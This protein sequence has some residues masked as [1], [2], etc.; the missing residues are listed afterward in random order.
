V[1][2]T[3]EPQSTSI[4]QAIRELQGDTDKPVILKIDIDH[5]EWANFEATPAHD[6]ARCSQIIGEFHGFENALDI[7]WLNRAVA[8]MRK[9][10][11]HFE[12]VHVHANNYT[13]FTTIANIAFPQT[14]EVSF[15]NRNRYR[16]EQTDERFPTELDAPNRRGR[17]DLYLGMFKY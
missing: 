3:G 5:D 1:S 17:A 7:Q 13:G 15:A 14:L 8:V 11:A 10:K 12:V 4:S 9:L 6:L 2:P 16:F